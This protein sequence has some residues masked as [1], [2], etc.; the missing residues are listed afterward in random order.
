M[1]AMDGCEAVADG[2]RVAAE[3]QG[4][5]E[6]STGGE[7][8]HGAGA[9]PESWIPCTQKNDQSEMYKKGT[10]AGGVPESWLSCTRKKV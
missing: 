9:V 8:L 5:G 2:M 1:F 7:W 6:Q 3:R 10:V 4:K